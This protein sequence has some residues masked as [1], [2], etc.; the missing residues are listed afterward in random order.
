MTKEDKTYLTNE[1]LQVCPLPVMEEGNGIIK[2]QVVSERGSTHWLN[3]TPRQFLA[4]EKILI[5]AED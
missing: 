4:I 5:K 3:I 2:I 1:M